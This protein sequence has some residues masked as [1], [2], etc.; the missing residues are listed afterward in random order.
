MIHVKHFIRCEIPGQPVCIMTKEN[1]CD[2]PT[3]SLG[4]LPGPCQHDIGNIQNLPLQMLD[5]D[6]DILTH[7][8]PPAHK[9]PSSLKSATKFVGDFVDSAL[10]HRCPLCH[11]GL[12]HAADRCP[13][14]E[15]Q[16]GDRPFLNFGRAHHLADLAVGHITGRL[17]GGLYAHH[18]REF[19]IILSAI[20]PPVIFLAHHDMISGN[21]DTRHIAHVS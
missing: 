2:A 4:E 21:R 17:L 13:S 10:E 15:V 14:A 20:K 6:K 16:A 8:L 5:D 1:G 3:R 7:K 19:D 9:V 12:E 18:R 11:F